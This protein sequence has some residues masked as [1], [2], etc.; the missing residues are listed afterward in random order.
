MVHLGLSNA[1]TVRAGK[2]H[3]R[4]DVAGLAMG[5]KVAV[6]LSVGF[7]LLTFAVFLTVPEVLIGL[8]LD[9]AEPARPEILALGTVLLVYCALFQTA[10]GGQ[11]LALG[12]L[13]GVQDTRVPMIMASVSYWLIGLPVMYVAGFVLGWGAEGVWLGLVIGLAAAGVSLM[14]R[15]WARVLPRLR[16]EETGAA[17]AAPA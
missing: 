17:E 7:A 12:L 2:A 3:G 10:D 1:A 16:A 8:F 14:W 4:G 13:R 6:T 9:P 5:A 11:A 15:F